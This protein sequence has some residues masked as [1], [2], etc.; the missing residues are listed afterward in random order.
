MTAPCP[1]YLLAA[2]SGAAMLVAAPALAQASGDSAVRT[3]ELSPEQK[4]KLLETSTETSAE[5]ARA[6]RSTARWAR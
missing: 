6:D 4:A 1:H 2:L 5:A 3:Y